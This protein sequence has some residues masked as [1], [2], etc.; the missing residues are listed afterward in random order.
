MQKL[1]QQTISGSVKLSGTGL[2]TGQESTI[3]FN[4]AKENTG[5]V[6]VRKDLHPEQIIPADAN[7][8]TET[9]RGTSLTLGEHS[10]HTTEHVLAALVGLGID[11]CL[12]ELTASEPPIMDGSSKPFI[13]ALKTVNLVT[14]D[15]EVD[16]FVVEEPLRFKDPKSD[17]EFILIPSEESEITCMVDY[18]TRVLGTQYAR[19]HKMSDF[20]EEISSAR[21]FCFLH[22]LEFLIQNNLIKGGDLNNAIV[23]VERELKDEEMTSL[24]KYFNRSQVSVRANGVLDNISLR[25]TNEPARHK[26]LDIVGDFA[27]IGKRIKGK[28]IAFKP[29]HGPN[30]R[31]AKFIKQYIAQN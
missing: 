27:L 24:G 11:N 7:L 12:I 20:E 1:K 9:D 15:E 19:L 29:G 8:V 13:D 16:E 21:T 28:I 14:Q 4:P 17:A 26:L 31:C 30:T 2:H 25:Y 18:N 3:T 10:I 6:F 5:F 22:E 23:F